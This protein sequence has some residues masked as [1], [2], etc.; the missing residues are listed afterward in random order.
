MTREEFAQ[1]VV[2]LQETL[3]RVSYSIIQS[4]EDQADA[5]QECIH[6]AL[7]KRETLREDRYLKTWL[8]RILI[9]ECYTILRK[10]KRE[11]PAEELQVAAPPMADRELHDA[12]MAL[13]E[14][15]RLP[16]V[17]HYM[18]GYSITEAAKAMRI[19]EATVKTRLRRARLQLKALLTEEEA[20][21][22]GKS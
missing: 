2:A 12:V 18:E 1:Q 9:N 11:F 21:G 13:E 3:Y 5:V 10:R 4:P 7:L 15:Y 19:P 16:I 17:L 20:T 6:K 8:I 22:Y 14:K